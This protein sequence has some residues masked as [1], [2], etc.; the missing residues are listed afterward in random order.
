MNYE[1][2]ANTETTK[3]T[4]DA[5]LKLGIEAVVVNNCAEALEKVK[6]LIQKGASVM[7]GASRTLEEIGFVD[8]LKSGNHGWKNLHEEILVEKD[9][10]K[11]RMLRKQAVLADYYL[12]SVHAIAETGEFVIASNSCSQLPQI[13]QPRRQVRVLYTEEADSFSV[14]FKFFLDLQKNLSSTFDRPRSRR[15]TCL[16][17][18]A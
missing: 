5:L 4:A 2:L 15:K 3:K 17:V 12:G 9:P 11:Q 16:S 8:Y 18:I 1:T 6:S 13:Q 7:K 10:I 14:T